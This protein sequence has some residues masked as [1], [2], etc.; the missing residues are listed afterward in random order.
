[1]L[2]W[3]SFGT[4][5][6]RGSAARARRR[7]LSRGVP[8]GDAETPAVQGRKGCGVART[9]WRCC[10]NFPS[11]SCCS[12]KRHDA[13]PPQQPAQA[14]RR[15]TLFLLLLKLRSSAA[16]PADK[17]C[18]AAALASPPPRSTAVAP[19]SAYGLRPPCLAFPTTLRLLLALHGARAAGRPRRACCAGAVQAASIPGRQRSIPRRP[20]CDATTHGLLVL[21]LPSP[22]P[23]GGRPVAGALSLAAGGAPSPARRRGLR[24]CDP[25]GAPP[26]PAHHQLA[27]PAPCALRPLPAISSEQSQVLISEG[28]CP[29][30]G[31][32]KTSVVI[33]IGAI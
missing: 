17:Q 11:A 1:M 16:L 2:A 25:G 28:R 21:S 29:V 32:A 12:R 22:T 15:S 30:R 14:A 26:P 13:R 19:A 33:N 7:V 24:E 4:P 3:N 10:S 20:R 9:T 5:I 27:A 23:S 6:P 31:A 18:V 8:T